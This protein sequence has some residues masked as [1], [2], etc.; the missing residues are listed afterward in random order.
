MGWM[1][2]TGIVPRAVT[3]SL[4]PV[5]MRR[6][7][8]AAIATMLALLSGTV[9]APS[10]HAVPESFVDEQVVTGLSAPTALA[11]LPDGRIIV[12]E[13]A[14]QAR[15]VVD[16]ALQT[17]PL[18]SMTVDARGER[19]L[20]GVAV[21]PNFS[22]NGYVYFYHTVPGTTVPVAAAYNQVTRFTMVG[23]AIDPATATTILVLDDLGTRTNHNGG[24]MLF[25]ADGKLYVA[26]GDARTSANAQ[27]L[28]TRHGKLLRVND[29][30]SIPADNPTSFAGT[31]GVTEG[32][33]RAIF[34]IGLRNPYRIAVQ[35]NTGRIFINDVG[36][37][38]FEEINE[39]RA[40]ANYGWPTT[41]G[42]TTLPNIDGP[43]LSYAQDTGTPTGCAIT[44]GAF[45]DAGESGFPAAYDGKY[46]FTDYCGNWI[47]FIDPNAAGTPTLFHTGLD[48]PV[49]LAMGTDAALYYLQAGNGGELRRIRYDVPA[50]QQLMV[51][52]TQLEVTEGQSGAVTARLAVAPAGIETVTARVA[53]ADA[54]LQVAPSTL[55]FDPSN[56]DVPQTITVLAGQDA[57]KRDEGGRVNLTLGALAPV[58]VLVTT[59]EDDTPAGTPRARITRPLPGEVVSGTKAEFFGTGTDDQQVVRGDFYIANVLRYTDLNSTGQYYLG[60]AP[61]LWDTTLL[62]N[63]Y[64]TV[65]LRVID[66]RGRAGHHE[67]KIRILN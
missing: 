54:S 16:G 55:T 3:P 5:G 6:D 60:G 26:V 49:D 32:D 27:S 57:D 62:P 59:R 18:L 56:W 48:R 20:V 41:E 23:N 29:D 7:M 25:G 43:K 40:G 30:G 12:T 58:G 10:A 9:L 28:T 14:G 17:A 39:A 19:G 63:G 66:N 67:V 65:R 31:T 53:F 50:A 11:F 24:G 4:R 36:E 52:A 51:S 13:Q 42:P 44:G 15:L 35:R 34:A 61:G 47:Y 21:H 22:E 1:E 33:D 46:Y 37:N 8:K 45:Y 2:L 38:R 64:Y